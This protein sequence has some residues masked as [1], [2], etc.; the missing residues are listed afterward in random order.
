MRGVEGLHVVDASIMPDIPSGAPNV[1]DDHDG[2]SD[3]PTTHRRL[4]GHSP[5]EGAV[6]PV[7]PIDDEDV[8]VVRALRAE[9]G[10]FTAATPLAADVTL[11]HTTNDPAP[12]VWVRPSTLHRSAPCCSCTAVFTAWAALRLT[13]VWSARSRR[14]QVSRRSCS[15]IPWPPILRCPKHSTLRWRR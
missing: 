13:P 9:F 4:A 5:T 14:G 3:Q 2:R 1:T 10:R 12:G 11:Q 15:T 8:P 6:V 7:I